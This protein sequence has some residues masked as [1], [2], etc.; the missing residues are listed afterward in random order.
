MNRVTEKNPFIGLRS[1]E[2]DESI[3]FFGRHEQTLELLQKLH[4]FHFLAVIGTSGSGKSSLVKAGL[5]PQLKAGYLVNEQSAWS[6]SIMKPGDDP[7]FNLAETIAALPGKEDNISIPSLSKKQIQEQGTDAILDFISISGNDKT[8]FFLLVD[9]FEEIF[10]FSFQK[11]EIERKDEST[12]FVNILLELSRQKDINFYV[13]ITMRS[14]FIGDCAQFYGLPEAINKGLYLVPRLTRTQLELI[15][16][17]PIRL[18]NQNIDSSLTDKVL[19]DLQLMQDEL[20]LLQHVLLRTWDYEMNV[21]KSGALDIKDYENV[22]GLQNALSKHADEVLQGMPDEELNLTKKIFQALTA[23]DQNGRKIRRPAHLSELAVI[24]GADKATILKTVNRFIEGNKSF[25]ITSKVEDKDDLLIDISHESLIRQWALLNSWV[26]TEADSAKIFLRLIESEKLY[27]EGNKNLLGGNELNQFWQWYFSFNPGP[28][29]AKRYSETFDDCIDYLKKSEEAERKQ[30]AV[31]LRNR[32]ILVTAVILVFITVSFFSLKVYSD[33][34]KSRKQLALSYWTSSQALVKENNNLDALHLVA[35]AAEISTQKDITRDLL[36]NGENLLPAACL[37]NM[38][39]C[40]D[41]INS[42][43]FS[44]DGKLIL[45]ACGDGTVSITDKTSGE[46]IRDLRGSDAPVRSAKF[47]A[48]GKLIVTGSADNTARIWNV[49]SGE[50]MHVFKHSTSISDVSFS[51]NGKFIITACADSSAHIWDIT[52]QTRV[53]SFKQNAAVTN[54]VFNHDDSKVLTAADDSTAHLW[55]VATGRSIY[56]FHHKSPLVTTAVF[57]AD[58][59]QILTANYDSAVYLW[60][61][62][63]GQLTDSVKTASEI[64]SVTLSA[65]GKLILIGSWNNYAYLWNVPAHKFY[66]LPFKHTATVFGVA[67]S[68]DGKWF[69]TGDGDKIVRLWNINEASAEPLSFESDGIVSHA[70]FSND[71]KFVLA[72]GFDSVARIWNVS[73]GKEVQRFSNDNRIVNAVFSPDGKWVLTSGADS[74]AKLWNVGTGRQEV[75]FKHDNIVNS[76]VFNDNNSVLTTGDDFIIKIWA[77]NGQLQKSFKFKGEVNNGV[78][79]PDKKNILITSNSNNAYLLNAENG[80]V[81]REFP[82]NE[83]IRTAVFSHDG[84]WVLTASWDSTARMWDA[85][86]GKQNGPAMKHSSYLTGAVFS[87]D[88]KWILTSGYD[89]TVRIWDVITKKQVSSFTFASPV[90]SAVF[91]SDGRSILTAGR[92]SKVYLIK[93]PGDLDMPA[94]LFKLQAQTLTGVKYNPGTNETEC[95]LPE[96]WNAINEQYQKEAKAHYKTCKYPGYNVWRRFN[97]EAAN[98]AR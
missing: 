11:K 19:N 40:S 34:I 82:H 38:F 63:T 27:K 60:N 17:A 78:L 90:N 88:G 81:V 74:A 44:A 30:K 8:N 67:F 43:A 20:P 76:A 18:Y 33:Y 28:A 45:A 41:I 5:I 65:D 3:L 39:E 75:S 24:T 36:L 32:R 22:G 94:S 57:T 16:E 93:I 55:D 69:L 4:K 80:K 92:D 25:L 95:L 68:E 42:V 10:R 7:L 54:A 66:N 59:K 73:D 87:A 52:Q 15:V 64:T 2:S 85:A 26:D 37:K 61:A 83:S 51:N 70:V 89:L 53:T 72:C 1:Y 29:W 91:S 12:D 13:G 31:R 47:S 49:N 62:E 56:T 48:D 71:Q 84:K 6:I 58:D 79:S 96:Q 9:Q 50:L 21:D 35:E 86:T 14:D 97:M 23:V 77:I 46:K 98:E